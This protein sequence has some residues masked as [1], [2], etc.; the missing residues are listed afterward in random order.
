[1]NS[2]GGDVGFE[3][4]PARLWKP[5]NPPYWVLVGL[6]AVPRPSWWYCC[7]TARVVCGRVPR[8]G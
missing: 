8:G 1:M 3:D 6:G 5:N 4:A 2:P 7:W